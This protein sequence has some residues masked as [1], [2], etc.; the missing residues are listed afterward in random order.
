MH[1]KSSL[2][3][4]WTLSLVVAR[5]CPYGAMVGGRCLGAVGSGMDGIVAFYGTDR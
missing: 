2:A 1:K 4:G 5:G 3:I